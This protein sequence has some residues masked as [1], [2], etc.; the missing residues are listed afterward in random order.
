MER[1]ILHNILALPPFCPDF[2]KLRWRKD[3]RCWVD[4][5]RA[6]AG[7]GDVR[8]KRM[9]TALGMFLYRSLPPSPQQLVEKSLEAGEIVL[10]AAEPGYSN[11]VMDGI[12]KII[13]IVAKDSALDSIKRL[14]KPGKAATFSVRYRGE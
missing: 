9:F 5:V 4:A 6:F 1:I 10:G 12:E 13:N 8:A 7:G 3:V 2:D 14:P 11:N